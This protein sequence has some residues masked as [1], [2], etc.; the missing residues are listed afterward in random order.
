MKTLHLPLKAK[1]Y[2]MIESGVKTEEYREKK[3][4]W[5]KRFA[6][7]YPARYRGLFNSCVEKNDFTPLLGKVVTPT[8]KFVKFYYGYTRRTMIFEFLHITLDKGKSE[9]GAPNEYV[10]IIKLG[11]RY[12]D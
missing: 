5:I 3:P 8:C 6:K 10:F 11:K 12:D 4:H 7:I 1:W 2:E 9:W